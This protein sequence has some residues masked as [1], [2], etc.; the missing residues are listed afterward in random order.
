MTSRMKYNFNYDMANIFNSNFK[1]LMC[2]PKQAP[3][4]DL[5][6][7]VEKYFCLQQT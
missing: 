7:E 5:Q 2:S 6:A 3:D 4:E 1:A